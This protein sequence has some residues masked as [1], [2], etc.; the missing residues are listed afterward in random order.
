MPAS[1]ADAKNLIVEVR[2]TLNPD[3]SLS[4]APVVTNSGAAIF[5]SSRKA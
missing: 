2:I 5:R 3:G 4:S 1:A